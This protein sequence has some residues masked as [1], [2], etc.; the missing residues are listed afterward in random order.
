ML[1]D[2]AYE[3]GEALVARDIVAKEEFE[4]AM[5]SSEES[6]VSFIEILIENFNIDKNDIYNVI[7]EIYN[8]PYIDLREYVS[9]PKVVELVS[10]DLS[11]KFIVFPVFKIGNVLTLT[12]ADPTDIVALDQVR[13][14]SEMEV[15]PC[16]SSKKDILEGINKNYR[17]TDGNP[18]SAAF[19]LGGTPR[20]HR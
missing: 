18:Q 2:N 1:E 6:G 4:E 16:L 10:E 13:M 9:D 11:R 14:N 3:I 5:N 15:E 20:N 17:A 8:V 7:A 12:M 19:S